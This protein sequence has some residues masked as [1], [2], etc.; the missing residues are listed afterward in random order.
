MLKGNIVVNS[1]DNSITIILKINANQKNV[2]VI[3]KGKEIVENYEN[4]NIVNSI[5]YFHD[6]Q[7][8]HFKR[9]KR[10]ITKDDINIM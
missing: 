3:M 1:D 6:M 9:V 4:L 10:L 2:L 5:K 8:K 7:K